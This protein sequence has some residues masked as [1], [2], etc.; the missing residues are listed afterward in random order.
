L[1]LSDRK[2]PGPDPG[3]D[4][5]ITRLLPE[6]ARV[7]SRWKPGKP[8][9][10]PKPVGQ[11]STRGKP[12]VFRHPFPMEFQEITRGKPRDFWIRLATREESS[13]VRFAS[14]IRKSSGFIQV[15]VRLPAFPLLL[16]WLKP[17][18]PTKF[19]RGK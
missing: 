8:V 4:L 13:L 2:N 19:L 1:Y 7:V 15:F 12:G 3:G 5:V 16:P 18:F 9:Q 6:F 10:N 14:R 17:V 11:V